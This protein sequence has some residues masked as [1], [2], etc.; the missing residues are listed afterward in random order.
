M[1]V[2]TVKLCISMVFDDCQDRMEF[3]SGSCLCCSRIRI[4][5]LFNYQ[6][7][8]ESQLGISVMSVNI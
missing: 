6:G 4:Y 2:G 8:D 5:H 7:V 1:T 3:V